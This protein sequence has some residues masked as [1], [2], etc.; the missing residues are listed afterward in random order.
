MRMALRRSA[1]FNAKCRAL[2]HY[3]KRLTKWLERSI[4]EHGVGGTAADGS[5]LPY[6]EGRSSGGGS[7]RCGGIRAQFATWKWQRIRRRFG[8][9]SRK[10]DRS[11]TSGPLSSSECAK[12]RTPRSTKN[13]APLTRRCRAR[14]GVSRMPAND[15]AWMHWQDCSGAGK[16]E[17]QRPRQPGRRRMDG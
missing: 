15:S 2:T 17:R 3:F 11:R 14:V 1:Y 6:P 10:A 9:E 5:V 7:Y 4:A 12:A 16:A 8:Q 13:T